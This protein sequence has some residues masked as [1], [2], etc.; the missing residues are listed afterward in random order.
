MRA[1]VIV[2]RP[3]LRDDDGFTL[4]ELLMSI[5]ILGVIAA[6][7]AAVVIGYFKN[8]AATSARLNESHDAQ[9]AAAYFAQDVQGIGV[10]DYDD[11]TS[12]YFPL[13]QSVETAVAADGGSNP[14][15]P[16]G[17]P[18]PS[19]GSPGTTSS[20]APSPRART[21]GWPTSW[22]APSCTGTGA[23][24]PSTVKLLLTI[25]DPKSAADY[26]VTLTGQRR[27]S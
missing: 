16:A 18:P 6:P 27:Q 21:P 4:V 15:G 7:L 20:T 22:R 2:L 13:L 14:C 24:V 19:S 12:A 25:R 3:R 1:G 8:S 26:H 5:V 17:T 11:T 23:G 9:I 10:R